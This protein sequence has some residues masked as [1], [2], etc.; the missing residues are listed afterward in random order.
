M[1]AGARG[2]GSSRGDAERKGFEGE[3]KEVTE[4][5]PEAKKAADAIVPWSF[6]YKCIQRIKCS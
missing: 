4:L 6:V 1:S 3:G 2:A 5:R